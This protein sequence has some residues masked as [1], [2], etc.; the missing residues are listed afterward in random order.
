MCSL[1]RP[2]VAKNHNFGQILAFW[3]LLYRPSFTDECQIWC[4]IADP[5]STFTCEINFVS[6]GLFCRPVAAKNPNFAV[7][8]RFFRL[9]HLVMSPIVINLRKLSTGA[10]LQTFPYPTASKSFLYT[11]ALMAKS[12]AQS[13]TFKSVTNKQ[14]NKQTNKKL[15]VFG[16][17]GGG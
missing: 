14:T 6:I 13:L 10:Q 4:A 15:N 3:G 8:C 2:P 9:R 17:P 5:R 1:C 7:F 12:G 16:C 11:K